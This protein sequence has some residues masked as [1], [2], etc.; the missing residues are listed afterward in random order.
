MF[1]TV[2]MWQHH[3]GYNTE[4]FEKLLMVDS[5]RSMEEEEEET[6]IKKG[7]TTL[8]SSA[9]GSS[10]S[11]LGDTFFLSLSFFWCFRTGVSRGC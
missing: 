11:E 2:D 9:D 10:V 5:D 8:F 4:D 3:F 6:V 1:G 7:V